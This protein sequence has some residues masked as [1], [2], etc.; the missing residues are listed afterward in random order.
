MC[1]TE[2]EGEPGFLLRDDRARTEAWI[3]SLSQNIALIVEGTQFTT[4]DDE[5]DPE[6]STI[7]LERS[8]ANALL[9][10]AREHLADVDAALTRIAEDSYGVC[11]RCGGAISSARLSALPAAR[12]CISCA[13]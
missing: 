4:I 7:A 11:E 1:P 6:G 12:T 13:G 2:D 5:H 10:S 3:L 9:A 8:Q